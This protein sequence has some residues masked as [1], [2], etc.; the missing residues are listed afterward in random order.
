M[1][2]NARWNRVVG[3]LSS[4][5]LTLVCLALLMALTVICTLAQVPR[6]PGRRGPNHPDLPGLVAAEAAP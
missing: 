5:K 4:L 1:P 3:A 2:P 6:D